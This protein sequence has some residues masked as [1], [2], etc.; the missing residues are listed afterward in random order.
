ML[1][2]LETYMN[3]LDSIVRPRISSRYTANSGFVAKVGSVL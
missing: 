1:A 3:M 2:Q